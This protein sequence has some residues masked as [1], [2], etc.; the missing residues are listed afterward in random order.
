MMERMFRLM[1]YLLLFFELVLI[2]VY[3][4]M[5]RRMMLSSKFGFAEAVQ[6]IKGGFLFS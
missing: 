5:M 4:M 1:I 6:S 3:N 2:S